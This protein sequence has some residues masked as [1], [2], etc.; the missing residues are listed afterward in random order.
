MTDSE[1]RKVWQ[2]KVKTGHRFEYF[3]VKEIYIDS[4]EQILMIPDIA[5]EVYSSNLT[6][7]IDEIL[8]L[9]HLHGECE[10]FHSEIKSDIGLERFPSGTFSVNQLLL[11]I[12]LLSV[13]LLRLCGQHALREDDGQLQ[14]RNRFKRKARYRTRLRSIIQDLMYAAARVKTTGRRFKLSFGRYFRF[15]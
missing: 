14:E 6:L 10:Q 11:Q 15:C 12:V 13:N 9:Y 2:G 3:K 5:V 7:D 4:E 1:Y 8:E